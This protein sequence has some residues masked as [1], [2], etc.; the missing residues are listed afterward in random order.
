MAAAITASSSL[1]GKYQVVI[2]GHEGD[3]R[4]AECARK[5]EIA[6][7]GLFN[8]RGVPAKKF[9]TQML[10]RYLSNN[11]YHGTLAHQSELGSAAFVTFH[12]LL[13]AIS[14]EQ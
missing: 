4:V 3:T 9:L 12:P 10:H 6:L 5:L 7:A 2:F 1:I 8:D 13:R 11:L 14:T